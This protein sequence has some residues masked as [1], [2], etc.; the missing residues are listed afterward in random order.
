MTGGPVLL[1][2]ESIRAGAPWLAGTGRES[3]VVISSRVRL[4]R[5]L[6]AFPFPSRATLAQRAQ[7][8]EA[9]QRHLTGGALDGLTPGDRVAWAPV[10]TLSAMDRHLLVERHLMSKEH[11]R[12]I[13]TPGA[14]KAAPPTADAPKGPASGKAAEAAA[15]ARPADAGPGEAPKTPEPR[16]IAFTL[17]DESLSVMVNEEDHLR[18]QV[19]RSG[20]ALSEAWRQADEADDRIEAGLAYAYAPRFGYLTACPTNVGCGVRMSAMLH[21]PGLRLSGEIEK[22]K[23]ATR[24]MNLAL[25]GFYGENSEAAGDLYQVS[26]QMTLGKPES[27]ILHELEREILPEIVRYERDARAG[28]M[29]RKRRFLE[30]QVFR[31]LG[32]LRHARLL[33]PEEALERLSLVRLGAMLGLIDANEPAV[34]R[35]F[36]LTQPAHLQRLLG[37]EMDQGTRREARADFVR[38]SLGGA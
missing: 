17:P 1:P 2:P 25:R 13:A 19:L 34:T 31:A 18:V 27:A 23:R 6:V 35:L 8:L 14:T 15:E 29:Q 20:L 12:G 16:G 10:H 38:T 33:T 7:T 22:V 26:N 30:D 4:A 36:L 32:V 11:A 28:L 3:D 37:R 9:C 5:N 21:L 24:D